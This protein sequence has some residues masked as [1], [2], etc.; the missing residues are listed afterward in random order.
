LDDFRY[1]YGVAVIAFGGSALL[2]WLSIHPFVRFWRGVGAKRTLAVHWSVQLALAAMVFWQ[3]ERIM[4]GDLGTRW[5]FVASGV[6]F[7]V[8]SGVLRRWQARP[9]S[10][11][12][13][14]GLPELEPARPDNRLVT[15]GIYAR[16]RHPRYVQL[17]LGMLGHTLIV[18]FVATYAL[19]IFV[20]AMIAAIVRF[21]EREL[22]ERFGDAY[23]D[24]RDR[25]PRF[26]PSRAGIQSDRRVKS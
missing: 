25:V 18:N 17:W 9:F 5:P 20:T 2:I 10:I 23:R 16:I 15:D 21:E 8:F 19:L 14:T 24:Y 3:H 26:L 22:V 6:V 1:W 12:L 11:A 4:T 7:L 13:L